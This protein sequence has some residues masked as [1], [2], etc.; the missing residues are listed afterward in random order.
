MK[1]EPTYLSIMSEKLH[2][3]SVFR[4]ICILS[5]GFFASCDSSNPP[6]EVEPPTVPVPVELLPVADTK[7]TLSNGRLSVRLA[8]NGGLNGLHFDLDDSS[9]TPTRAAGVGSSVGLW[10]AGPQNGIKSNVGSDMLNLILD[11]FELEG[12]NQDGYGLYVVEREDFELGFESWPSDFGAPIYPNG[13]PKML[14]DAMVWGV[15]GGISTSANSFTGLRIVKTAYVFDDDELRNTLFVRYEVS[16]RSAFP[17]EDLHIGFGADMDLGWG[18]PYSIPPCGR[19]NPGWNH[20]GYNLDNNYSYT[21]MKPD[22]SDG[23][24]SHGCYGILVGYT[25]LGTSSDN[26]LSVPFLSH[27][28]LTKSCAAL[29]SACQ[30]QTPSQVLLALQGLSSEG[31]PMIDPTTGEPTNFAFTGN[32]VTEMGW[33]D[34]RNEVRS[35]LALAPISLAPGETVEFIVPIFTT[36]SPSF[37]QGYEDLATLYDKVMSLRSTWDY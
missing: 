24:L 27:R 14:G 19:Q 30:I 29:F 26:G 11:K 17:I 23:N 21:Y 9:P 32:P 3:L 7:I 34:T 13:S 20:S 1:S 36:I 37:E 5:A 28:V 16:N 12:Q 6:L 35:L 25:I 2:S 8:A 33:V 31:A 4:I 18:G 10:L 15:F 22:S